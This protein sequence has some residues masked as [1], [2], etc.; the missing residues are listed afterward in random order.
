MGEYVGKDIISSGGVSNMLHLSSYVGFTSE[1][2][3]LQGGT[4]GGPADLRIFAS[5]WMDALYSNDLIS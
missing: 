2:K 1:V 4:I 3:E 5:P